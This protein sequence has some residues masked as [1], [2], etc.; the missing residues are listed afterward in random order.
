MSETNRISY[1]GE[2]GANS[3]TACRNMY[4]DME[5]LPCATFED[6]FNAVET[7]KADLGDDPHREHHCRPRGRHPP[8]AAGIAPPHHRRVFSAHP[9]PSD[10]AARHP[11]G[12]HQVG[13]QPHPCARPVPQDHPPPSLEVACRRRHRWRRA[14]GRRGGRSDH[15]GA[16]AAPGGR[17]LR[18]RHPRRERRGHREQHHPL[19][20]AVEGEGLGAAPRPAAP[21][22]DHLHLP[23]PQRAGRA[24]QGARRLRHQRRQHDQ[25][26]E[27]PARRQVLLHPVLFRHRGPPRRP[28]RRARAWR[29]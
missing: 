6:A 11:A 12:G 15:G 22:D 18:A 20:R 2:P 14:A 5:P 3:D 8:P 17:A 16:G 25:A 13:A 19:R 1:Q 28:P 24:L 21:H 29:S 26:G 7:G 27:L 9:L 4:P 10:G 23:R